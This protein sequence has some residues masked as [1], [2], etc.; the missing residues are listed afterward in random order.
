[1]LLETIHISRLDELTP[2]YRT[3]LYFSMGYPYYV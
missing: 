3:M 2:K 1:M